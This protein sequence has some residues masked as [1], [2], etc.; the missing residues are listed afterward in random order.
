MEIM[1]S[2]MAELDSRNSY[3][4]EV[5]AP[6]YVCSFATHVFNL[7]NQ[8]REVYWEGKKLPNM[9]LHIL[10]VAPP[11][12]MKTYYMSVMGGDKYSVFAQCGIKMGQEQAI[13]EAG[14][15]GTFNNIAGTPIEQEGAARALA[16]GI[17]MIDEFSAI[18]NA[19]KVQ[20]N[21][22]MDSQLLA[23]LDHGNVNKRLGSGKIEY[24]TNF[25]L[26]AG[27]QPARYDLT[28][29]LGRRMCFLLFLPIRLDNDKLLEAMH[30]ARGI[31]P[32]TIEINELW[33]KI[34]AWRK[35]MDIIDKVTYDDDVF[36]MYRKLGIF[37]YES[38]YFD[39][40]I[41]GW[42]LATYGPDREI[43]VS[44]KHKELLE[45]IDRE[46]RWRDDIAQGVDYIQLLKMIKVYGVEVDGHI[47]ISRASLVS[48]GIM[49]GW[50]AQQ[51]YEMLVEMSKYGLVTLKGSSVLL[52]V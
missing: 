30:H 43:H 38:S 42:H 20:Y 34:E 47:D 26:W 39:R 10:F 3:K 48:E 46:K 36:Q 12:F 49:V 19:L 6:Y 18:T 1:S 2:I 32:S 11:G 29:G 50:N 25:T 24:Q 13:T 44:V 22:Q 52:E 45:I 27:V 21:S 14:L 31:R 33:G 9:R 23:A 28:S 35:S 8:T 51:I 37:S 15:I 17:L 4:R 7:M 5:Y 40:L 16:K 41:L